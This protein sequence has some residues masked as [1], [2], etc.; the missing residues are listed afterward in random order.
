MF[1]DERF[2]SLSER[3]DFWIEFRTDYFVYKTFQIS[4]SVPSAHV[5]LAEVVST[6]STLTDVHALQDTREVTVKSVR[7]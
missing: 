5:N 1:C 6:L 3:S 2:T 7:D 4:T